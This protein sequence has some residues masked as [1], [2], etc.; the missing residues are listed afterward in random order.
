MRLLLTRNRIQHSSSN[1][2][3]KGSGISPVHRHKHECEYVRYKEDLGGESVVIA[4]LLRED[5]FPIQQRD[6]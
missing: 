3:R 4:D 1:V 6:E 2:H 5:K